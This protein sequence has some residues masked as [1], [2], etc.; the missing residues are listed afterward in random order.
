MV[1]V[2]SSLVASGDHI[3]YPIHVG[4][5]L[6]SPGGKPSILCKAITNKLIRD[7]I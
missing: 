7:R 1:K 3:P 5:G 2:P 6:E 4:I